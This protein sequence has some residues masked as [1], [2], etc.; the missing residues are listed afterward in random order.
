MQQ[1]RY[2]QDIRTKERM[3]LLVLDVVYYN[4]I[5]VHISKDIHRSNKGWVCQWL[6]RY[7]EEGIEGLK[8]RPKS[9]RHPKI[10]KQTEFQ[11]KAILKESNQGWITK[12]IEE[13]VIEQSGIKYPYTHV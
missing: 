12:Q 3:L 9:G 10:S 4:K 1:S 2:E 11:I 13:L 7:Y 8:D 5:A 6:K